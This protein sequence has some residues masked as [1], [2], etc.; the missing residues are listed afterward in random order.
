[1]S[2]I[3]KLLQFSKQNGCSHIP[4]ALS[5]LTYVNFLFENKIIQPFRDRIVLGKPFGS[6]AYYIVWKTLGY[7]EHIDSLSVGVKHNEI[8]FVDYS[9]ETMGNALGVAIGIALANPNQ[10]VWVNLSDSSLQ[11]GS[12]LEALQYIGQYKLKNIF[13]T[14]DNN[15][16]QVTGHTCDIIDVNPVIEMTKMY[17]WVV[18]DI[19]GHDV[20][21]MKCK[22]SSIENFNSPILINFLTQKGH[23]V[24]CMQED[25]IKWHY[26][27]LQDDEI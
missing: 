10:S 19:K 22:L 11:M 26:K 21:Q 23:G 20:E 15:N 2:L 4:S 24:G 14:I 6:Q 16:C 17:G 18:I 25:P 27:L 12:T 7:L 5:M 3:D 9:E 8:P 1:M 13:L